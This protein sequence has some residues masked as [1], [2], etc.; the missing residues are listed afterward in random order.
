MK[1]IVLPIFAVGA[2]V[3]AGATLVEHL[4]QRESTEAPAPPPESPFSERVA[5][6]GLVEA[7]TENVAVGTHIAGIVASARASA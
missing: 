6:V 3:F 1:N 5:A 2:L 4:P 7:N